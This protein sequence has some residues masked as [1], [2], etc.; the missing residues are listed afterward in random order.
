MSIK[1]QDKI[2]N[3]NL[4]TLKLLVVQKDVCDK[5]LYLRTAAI[6]KNGGW[7]ENEAE[8]Q[9]W[10]QPVL[11]NYVSKSPARS[12]KAA[13]ILKTVYDGINEILGDRGLTK[14][15][16]QPLWDYLF[17]NKLSLRVSG[18]IEIGMT[19]PEANEPLVITVEVFRKPSTKE[20]AGIKS[21]IKEY[22]DRYLPPH[23]KVRTSARVDIDKDLKILSL[24]KGRGVRKEKIY[25]SIYL[26]A[27]KKQYDAGK[28]T[29]KELLETE[30]KNK[31]AVKIRKVKITSKTVAKKIYGTARATDKVRASATRTRKMIRERFKKV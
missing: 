20:L 23:R 19:S 28:I 30:R 10:Y 3:F 7:F 8:F 14:D 21:V 22:S 17:F 5:I 6:G 31:H 29:E 9:R 24:M 16:F 15:F 4:D 1:N 2:G 26:E 11:K 18:N 12:K 27:V 13:N 25:D